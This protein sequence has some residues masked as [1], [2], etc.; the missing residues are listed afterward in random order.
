MLSKHERYHG[1][2]M[3]ALVT[4][5]FALCTDALAGRM[6]WKT[7]MIMRG[8][9]RHVIQEQTDRKKYQNGAR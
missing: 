8:T 9:G 1:A 4:V 5:C 7:D 3:D 6:R 2:G